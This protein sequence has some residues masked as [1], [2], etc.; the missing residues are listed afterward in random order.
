[1][2]ENENEIVTALKWRP[3]TFK[4]VVGQ[5]HVVRTIMNSIRNKKYPH[6]YLF[7]GPR[8][9]G[10]TTT[11]RLVAKALNCLNPKD[12]EPC[13]ECTN[14]Q[15]ITKGSAVDVIEIDAASNGQVD[16]ARDLRDKIRYSPMS[17]KNKVII[18]DEVHMMTNNAFNALLKTLEEPPANTVFVLATTEDHKVPR[19]ISSRCQVHNFRS[20]PDIDIVNCLK[21]IAKAENIEVEDNA[22]YIIAKVSDGGLRDAQG[23]FDKVLGFNGEN[24]VTFADA[25]KAL[26]AV[27]DKAFSVLVDLILLKKPGDALKVIK[28]M[29]DAGLDLK[30]FSKDW[31]GYWSQMVALKI[32]PTQAEH[33]YGLSSIAKEAIV[34]QVQGFTTQDLIRISRDIVR[35]SDEMGRSN[36]FEILLELTVI[37]L[38][39]S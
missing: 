36:H 6:A 7:T 35:A 20:I 1:M 25:C 15:Q 38:C 10:K 32:D 39:G 22:L 29:C 37:S 2:A 30:R 26:G 5:E 33:L 17:C 14:C 13:N 12:G 11:A 8:G 9:V 28:G 18:I 34:R 16:D 31:V 23:L 27:D 21:G 4:E 19:T 3:T 24:K